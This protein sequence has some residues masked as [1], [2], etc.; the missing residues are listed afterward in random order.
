MQIKLEL[1][2]QTDTCSMRITAEPATSDEL[3]DL[4]QACKGFTPKKSHWPF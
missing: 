1:Q 3:R 4:L 2:K